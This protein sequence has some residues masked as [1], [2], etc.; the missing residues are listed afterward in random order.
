LN[1][2]AKGGLYK[3]TPRRE[4]IAQ[5][6]VLQQ[7]EEVIAVST[8]AGASDVDVETVNPDAGKVNPQNVA[9]AA[10][11]AEKVTDDVKE[12]EIKAPKSGPVLI[13]E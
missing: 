10:P 7:D 6:A 2:E 13:E 11:V 4:P 8:D 3:P 9:P 5:D 12:P 1:D